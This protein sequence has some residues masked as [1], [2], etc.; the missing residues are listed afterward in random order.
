MFCPSCGTQNSEP[1]QTCSKCGFVLKNLAVPKF[2][3]TMLMVNPSSAPSESTTLPAPQGPSAGPPF[4]LSSPSPA[5]AIRGQ[6][7]TPSKLKGTMVGVAPPIIAGGT[8]LP[9][10]F[11]DG[12][13][14]GAGARD[15]RGVVP[16]AG[17]AGS[18]ASSTV[19][20]ASGAQNSRL[21]PGGSPPVAAIEPRPAGAV[22][23]LSGTVA[24][25]A[26]TF[27]AA[28]A[29]RQHPSAPAPTPPDQGGAFR[30]G[31]TVAFAAQ[32]AGAARPEPYG[33]PY[34]QQAQ[35]PQGNSG[36]PQQYGSPGF[37]PQYGSP[38][39]QQVP[40]G[41]GS[42]LG[43]QQYQAN[44]VAPVPDLGAFDPRVMPQS[45]YQPNQM[46][47]RVQ[48]AGPMMVSNP[49]G[50]SPYAPSALAGTL[51]SGTS[52][53]VIGPTRRN[54]L[55]T[56]L[57]P[58]L[59]AIAGGIVVGVL[60]YFVPLLAPLASLPGL[61]ASVWYLIV[62]IRMI[63]ELQVA[64]HEPLPWWPIFVPLY[65]LYWMWLRVPQ[66]VA[67]AKQN[68]GVGRPPCHILLYIFFWPF[69]LATDLNEMV[70]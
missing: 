57:G 59:V 36:S 35:P 33:N 64:A 17:G 44:P 7:G 53:K 4:G 55:M 39:P 58:M 13:N 11:A 56:L 1:A 23:P 68:L 37:Q 15:A 19:A 22:N 32:N 70:R 24:A 2:K 5:G 46:S 25:D 9:V 45:P 21:S 30:A 42:A 43:A 20:F 50:I 48:Q 18:S 40:Q 28:Y 34:A 66:Q 41:Y 38:P 10:G 16:A 65:N 63:R 52:V 14:L 49:Q 29:P 26:S 69:A 62:A 31:Q 47:D 54:A 3:G 12:S 51:E 60:L 6:A 61:V 8:P 27:A 67:K